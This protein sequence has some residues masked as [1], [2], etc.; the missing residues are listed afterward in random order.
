[1]SNISKTIAVLGVV[2]GLGVAAL[3]LSTYAAPTV[4]SQTGGSDTTYGSDE[5]G[6]HF[7]KKDT[8]IKLTIEDVLSI[9]TGATEV[10]LTSTDGTEYTNAAPLN[11][12]VVSKNSKGYNLTIA[13]TADTNPTSLTNTVT[14]SDQITAGAGTFTAPAALSNAT[15]SEWG[16]SIVGNTTFDGG[17]YAGVKPGGE[18]IKT[19]TASTVNAGEKTQINFAAKIKDGQASG[20]YK[21]KV[22]FTA[23]NNP[24]TTPTPEA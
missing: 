1:M 21:G 22:T 2:A 18:T 4:W 15:T 6:N 23:T 5:D 10:E 11:V 12:T 8:D 9:D 14:S 13:G 17:L 24:N 20:T 19:S 16:Y 7:V 3:P